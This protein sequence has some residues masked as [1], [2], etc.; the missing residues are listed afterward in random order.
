[1]ILLFFFTAVVISS[2]TVRS[3]QE[4]LKLKLD[5]YQALTGISDTERLGIWNKTMTNCK[6]RTFVLFLYMNI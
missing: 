6:L 3:S 5:K 4:D 2:P 1:M